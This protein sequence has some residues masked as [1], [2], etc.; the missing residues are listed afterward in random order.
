MVFS[1]LEFLLR[2]LPVVLVLYFAVP[3]KFKNG[4]LLAASLFFYAW[5][6][7]VYIALIIVSCI[8]NY[9][10]SLWINQIRNT[11]AAK[12]ALVTAIIINLAL[13]GFFKYA[14]FLIDNLNTISDSNIGLVKFALAP[15][16]QLLHIPGSYPI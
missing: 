13:L 15:G 8:V 9:A 14:D 16:Y 2:F 6:D 12:I 11:P 4:I 5:G 7:P 10:F 1:S 3:A